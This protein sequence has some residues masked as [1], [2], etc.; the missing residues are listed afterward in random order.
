MLKDDSPKAAAKAATPGAKALVVDPEAAKSGPS[1]GGFGRPGFDHSGFQRCLQ[2]AE[3]LFQPETV[4]Y[5]A[6]RFPSIVL[7]N[8]IEMTAVAA[9]FLSLQTMTLH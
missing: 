9:A 6:S 1:F 5:L 4:T 2:L 7:Y 3:A 8:I